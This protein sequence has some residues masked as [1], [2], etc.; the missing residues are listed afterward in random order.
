MKSGDITWKYNT[1]HDNFEQSYL[2][3]AQLKTKMT[4]WKNG[5]VRGANPNPNPFF[6]YT[7]SLVVS[8]FVVNVV[9]ILVTP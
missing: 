2:Q 7:G 3:T 1:K 6:I 5:G 4:Q 9:T 8:R